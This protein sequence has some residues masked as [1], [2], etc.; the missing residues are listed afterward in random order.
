MTVVRRYFESGDWWNLRPAQKL[1]AEQ[2]GAEDSRRFIAV[3]RTKA[4]DW[5]AC[6]LPAGG[7]IRLQPEA[8][9]GSSARWFDARNGRWSPATPEPDASFTAPSSDDWVLDLRR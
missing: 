3:A 2:P 6:Y 9:A 5:T 8:A 4:D 7:T 1:L